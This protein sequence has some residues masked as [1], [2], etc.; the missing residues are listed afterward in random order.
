M[1]LTV[2]VNTTITACSSAPCL[3]FQQIRMLL[4]DGF[5]M[6]LPTQR[7]MSAGWSSHLGSGGGWSGGGR[8]FSALGAPTPNLVII[9]N[10]VGLCDR[11]DDR[12]W[13]YARDGT[14][15]MSSLS[16]ELTSLAGAPR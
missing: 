9:P 2:D 8:M 1:H 4:P 15:L 7:A 3:R 14:E 12:H 5:T 6:S 10:Q 11:L 13:R 16:K